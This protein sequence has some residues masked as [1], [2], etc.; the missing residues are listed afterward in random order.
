MTWLICFSDYVSTSM[1]VV[2]FLE[3]L[4][5]IL[6]SFALLSRVV[7]HSDYLIRNS[8][9]TFVWDGILTIISGM[10]IQLPSG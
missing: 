6:L 7:A 10:C 1:L 3:I 2:R 5:V 9:D 4:G 8:E